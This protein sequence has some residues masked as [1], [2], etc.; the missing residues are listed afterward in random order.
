MIIER[1]RFSENVKRRS[2]S[3]R[4]LGILGI[5]KLKR[6]LSFRKVQEWGYF[7]LMKIFQRNDSVGYL[8]LILLEY[9]MCSD[10][11]KSKGFGFFYKVFKKNK[12]MEKFIDLNKF[13]D[14]GIRKMFFLGLFSKKNRGEFMF[15]RSM[16]EFILLF[17][18]VFQGDMDIYVDFVFNFFYFSQFRR[19]YILV[20]IYDNSKVN[21]FFRKFIDYQK[22]LK[23]VN[24]NNFGL[25]FLVV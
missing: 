7:N 13:K 24:E 14:F 12:L 9:L 20:E 10:F 6:N 4:E 19:R 21:S 22:T 25:R 2:V 15:Q 3:F 5:V 23:F 8:L 16:D 17:I 11:G 1:K 18:V